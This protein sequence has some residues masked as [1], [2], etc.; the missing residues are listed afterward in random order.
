MSDRIENNGSDAVKQHGTPS[1][2]IAYVS[3]PVDARKI[4]ADALA[5]R[6]P[7]Y[8]GTSYLA[9]L[10]QIVWAGEGRAVVVT[11]L[12]DL[13]YDER[14]GSDRL[15]NIPPPTRLV[16]ARFHLAMLAWALRTLCLLW[17]ERPDV[18]ILTAS[19]NYF[20]VFAPLRWRGTAIVV[21]LHCT[22]WPK[23]GHAP[24]S[25]AWFRW[26]NARLVFRRAAAIQCV[27]SDIRDQVVTTVPEIA[28]RV[29]VFRPTYAAGQFDGIRAADFGSR[30]P[31]RILFV[32]RVEANKGPFDLL[33]AASKLR[34]HADMPR[35]RI[36]F[37]GEGSDLA[38]LRAA[39]ID[40][41][42]V[43]QCFVHGV[44]DADR[45][46]AFYGD[47]HIVVVPTRS[48]FEEGYNKVCAEAILAGRPV[49]TSAAC[50]ALA[51]IRQAAVEAQVDNVDSYA[52]AIFR[53]ATE[54]SL[55]LAKVAAARIAS[56][57]YYD[58]RAS[59]AARLKMT[60]SRLGM[61]DR[62]QDANIS[63]A[64]HKK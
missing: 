62:T 31:F 29:T 5:S 47:S 26:L 16:G 19:A 11:T 2:T 52:E 43:D 55:Y 15:V 18:V 53:L 41:G 1:P 23:F 59:Y 49:V 36:D 17:R 50:P 58:S 12:P 20:F 61:V 57:Q 25:W 6:E 63:A 37:C 7:A 4:H 54:E 13:A 46:R 38:R 21:S 40:L 24:R 44:C 39:V 42:L 56:S 35:F 32:G 64:T 60:L 45:V 30:N 3:G 34:A 9:Q 27:S 14:V 22:L 48:D 8:F 10:L 51:D 28:D 33:A